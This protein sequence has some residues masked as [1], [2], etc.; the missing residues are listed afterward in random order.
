MRKLFLGLLF[1]LFFIICMNAEAHASDDIKIY[2]NG[3]YLNLDNPIYIENDRI[4]VPMRQLFEELGAIVK[5][6]WMYEVVYARKT[7]SHKYIDLAVSIDY[8]R[9]FIEKE[10]DIIGKW[11][12]LDVP[13]RLINDRTY[14]PLRFVSEAFGAEVIFDPASNEVFI[15]VAIDEPGPFVCGPNT[16]SIGPKIKMAIQSWAQGERAQKIP[17]I[18]RLENPPLN[19]YCK[20][21]TFKNPVELSGRTKANSSLTINGVPVKVYPDGRFYFFLD[22]TE[23][24]NTVK[25]VASDQ[26]GYQKEESYII[27]YYP[28]SPS[29]RDY[30]DKSILS[31]VEIY[32]NSVWAV[33]S[34]TAHTPF[35]ISRGSGFIV[36]PNGVLITNYHV[37]KGAYKIEIV[38]RYKNEEFESII[39]FSE[40][41]DIAVLKLK[42]NNFDFISLTSDVLLD[43]DIGDTVYTIGN[44]MGFERSIS[45]GIV[46]NY[47]FGVEDEQIQ[48]TA[49]TSPGSSG[50]PLI[51]KSG[52]V[53]GIVTKKYKEG[54]NLNF[55]ISAKYVWKVMYPWMDWRQNHD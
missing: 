53:I 45:E 40:E 2:I 20:R 48:F 51:D 14:V 17:I 36:N 55:A 22:L 43:V 50:G 28:L 5:W 21:V 37:I 29:Y 23:G 15:R 33:V 35:G 47:R 39:A 6:D 7:I 4:L 8:P 32:N 44:P 54:E 19:D 24:A 13:P 46:S 9:A 34:I 18:L 1:T 49:A 26:Y 25:L 10:G 27:Y 31:P 30:E 52:R 16:D 38:R 41:K 3:K 12:D 42:G 11:V